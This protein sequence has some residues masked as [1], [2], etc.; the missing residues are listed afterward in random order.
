MRITVDIESKKLQSILKL[1]K[2]TKKSPAL[3]LALDEFI[4]NRERQEFLD[5]VM[6]GK[7][8]YAMSNDE[9][10]A[11]TDFNEL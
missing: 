9:I 4:Q 2:Q 11:L 5:K 7:T 8:E 3:A 10:E 6:A 1:T